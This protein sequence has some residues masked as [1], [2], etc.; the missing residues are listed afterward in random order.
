VRLLHNPT[1]R[2]EDVGERLLED[3]TEDWVVLLGINAE[4]LEHEDEREADVV[5]QEATDAVEDALDYE[6]LALLLRGVVDN[7]WAVFNLPDKH[8][9]IGD[10]ENLWPAPLGALC[11]INDDQIGLRIGVLDQPLQTTNVHLE[12]LEVDLTQGV[13][14]AHTDLNERLLTV[15]SNEHQKFLVF[16][17]DRFLVEIDVGF[18][19]R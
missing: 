14:I 13:R 6:L 12:V 18:G 2:L 16:D 19:L 15:L 10:V 9:A 4:E 11:L 1:Y 3:L 5:G 8:R 17:Q 7:Q